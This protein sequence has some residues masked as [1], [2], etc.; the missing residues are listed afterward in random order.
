LFSFKP[1][2]LLSTIGKAKIVA[3]T[4]VKPPE[5]VDKPKVCWV[6]YVYIGTGELAGRFEIRIEISFELLHE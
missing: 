4:P 5:L 6:D 1:H 2:T 3:P